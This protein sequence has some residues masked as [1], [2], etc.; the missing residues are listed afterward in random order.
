MDPFDPN[1]LREVGKGGQLSGG[2]VTPMH[3]ALC[4]TDDVPAVTAALAEIV[5]S[6][7]MDTLLGPGAT[8]T[9]EIAPLPQELHGRLALG[10]LAISFAVDDLD[11]RVAACR[12]AGLDVTVAVG[13]GGLAYA[14]VVVAG[15]EFELVGC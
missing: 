9:I 8:G 7:L 5:G 6:G 2:E 3:C 15:V 14:V 12:A 13:E 4:V 11:A 10:T 1:E